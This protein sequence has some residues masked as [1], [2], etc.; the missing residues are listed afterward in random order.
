MRLTRSKV[1]Q[2]HTLGLQLQRRRRNR[3]RRRNFNAA[4][5]VRKYLGCRC[6]AH[7][8]SVSDLPREIKPSSTKSPPHRTRL[9]TS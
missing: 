6:C 4:D 5:P 9:N 2:V 1:R 7:T 8:S 3:H